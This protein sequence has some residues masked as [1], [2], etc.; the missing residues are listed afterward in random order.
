MVSSC[1]RVDPFLP[2]AGMK[3]CPACGAAGPFPK[4]EDWLDPVAGKP[5]ALHECPACGVA[6][7]EPR[8]EFG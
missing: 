5:Y 3:P 7:S 1:H 8:V 4:V 6:F 2:G